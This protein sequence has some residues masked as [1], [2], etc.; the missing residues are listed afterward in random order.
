MPQASRGKTKAGLDS[1]EAR[2]VF[3]AI[4]RIREQRGCFWHRAQK[5]VPRV[6][7]HQAAEGRVAPA[8]ARGAPGP[9]RA[10]HPDTVSRGRASLRVSPEPASQEW[11]RL[12][13]GPTSNQSP[14]GSSLALGLGPI[15]TPP[16]RW[17]V[18]REGRNGR[19]CQGREAE[20]HF[21]GARSRRRCGCGC[22]GAVAGAQRTQGLQA[23]PQVIQKDLKPTEASQ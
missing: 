22:V 5:T 16:W 11:P 2:E 8:S 20:E 9:R 19:C 18:C 7:S 4:Y 21:P 23:P 3:S 6:I 14:S 17:G 15:R 10:G 12:H 13:A 1:A